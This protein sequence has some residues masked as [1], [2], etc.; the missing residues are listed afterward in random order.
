MCTHTGTSLLNVSC[1]CEGVRVKMWASVKKSPHL[2]I[3]TC[4][5]ASGYVCT[6]YVLVRGIGFM[7]I[8][9]MYRKCIHMSHICTRVSP[10]GY[11]CVTCGNEHMYGNECMRVTCGNEY[12][13]VWQ[14]LYELQAKTHIHPSPYAT[15]STC[16]NGCMY[17]NECMRITHGNEHVYGNNCTRVGV[18]QR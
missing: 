11:V 16:G 5:S 14:C 17:G 7:Y 13:N 6:I 10:S 9:H 2:H 8:A 4:V 18:H 3:C 1:T 12:V 15:H